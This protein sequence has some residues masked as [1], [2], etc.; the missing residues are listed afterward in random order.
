MQARKTHTVSLVK[1]NPASR[2]DLAFRAASVE[3]WPL[4]WPFFSE[5][6]RAADTYCCDPN[7]TS[8]AARDDWFHNAEVWLC[9]DVTTGVVLGSYHLAPNKEGPGAHIANGSYM[10]AEASRGRGVG[11]A[12]VEHSLARAAELGY[13]GMQFNAVVAT[14]VHAIALYEQLGFTTVGRVPGAFLH[15]REGYVDLLIMFRAV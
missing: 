10:V 1:S 13:R 4:I 6:V 8:E 5:I 15:P 12:M 9:A 11:R 7:V 3:D 14:N 2:T